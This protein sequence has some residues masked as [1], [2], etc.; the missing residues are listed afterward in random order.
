MTMS[1]S[2]IDMNANYILGWTPF[3]YACPK[4][5][6]D[7][8]KPLQKAIFSNFEWPRVWIFYQCFK[9][10]SGRCSLRSLWI[11]KERFERKKMIILIAWKTTSEMT[12]T[13]SSVKLIVNKS[14]NAIHHFEWRSSRWIL[15]AVCWYIQ[16]VFLCLN[17][18][19]LN[20]PALHFTQELHCAAM[21]I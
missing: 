8:V 4:G 21:I 7:V 13:T 19:L 5:Y 1:E 16:V 2:S 10:P 18:C 11:Q 12:I 15:V 6:K 20:S 3:M 17:G 14:Q 9:G